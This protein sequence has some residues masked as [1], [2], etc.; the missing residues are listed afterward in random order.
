MVVVSKKLLNVTFGQ[1][2]SN[3]VKNYKQIPYM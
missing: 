3:S 1:S 2:L